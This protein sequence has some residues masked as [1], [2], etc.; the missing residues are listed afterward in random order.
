MRLLEMKNRLAIE[1]VKLIFQSRIEV[2]FIGGTA[3]NTFYLDYRFS[4]DLD[5]GYL[6][7]N[8]KTEIN[9]LLRDSGYEI[10]STNFK[11]RDIITFEGTSLKMDV[12]KY[13]PKYNG[14]AENSIDR[15]A[16]K[17]LRLEE[18]AVE[19]MISFFT[20]EEMNGLGRDA[21]DLF[22]I[23]QKYKIFPELLEKTK[24]IVKENIVSKDHNIT[25]FE[26]NMETISVSV[27]PYLRKE[28]INSEDV[29][30]FLKHLR[31]AIYE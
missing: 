22:S 18:F 29:L 31:G 9:E 17:T 4:E 11:F 24:N 15:T 7:K 19:K 8:R 13:I 2:V 30:K 1:T 5:L 26:E 12:I 16:I 10:N 27:S 3:L 28:P 20:R 6:Q 14:I 21:Y 23:E 25:L